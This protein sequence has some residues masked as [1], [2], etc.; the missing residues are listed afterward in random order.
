MRSVGDRGE[1]G[2]RAKI[3]LA[4]LLNSRGLIFPGLAPPRAGVAEALALAEACV[5]AGAERADLWLALA[6]AAVQSGHPA[7]AAEAAEAALTASQSSPRRIASA[8]EVLALA[9]EVARAAELSALVGRI[10]NGLSR[11]TLGHRVAIALLD[12]DLGGCIDL[13]T[14]ADG[15]IAAALWGRFRNDLGRRWHGPAPPDPLDWFLAATPAQAPAARAPLAAALAPFA[16]A[17]VR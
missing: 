12:G 6:W 4:E 10:D 8:A 11:I 2:L 16:C 15:A 7:R 1:I 9:G 14:R 13:A 17:A 3:G 5:T